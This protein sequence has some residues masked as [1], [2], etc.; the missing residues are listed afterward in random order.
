MLKGNSGAININEKMFVD[1]QQMVNMTGST[2]LPPT[3]QQ[4]RIK[5]AGE[6]YN[7]RNRPCLNHKKLNRSGQTSGLS[8]SIERSVDNNSSSLDHSA[9]HI[10][11]LQR[12]SM[13][14]PSL[15][16][17]NDDADQ[18]LPMIKPDMSKEFDPDNDKV[19]MPDGSL[20]SDS[21][22]NTRSVQSQFVSRKNSLRNVKA[23]NN[24]SIARREAASSLLR[25][26]L[27]DKP[28]EVKLTGASTTKANRRNLKDKI[29]EESQRLK[30]PKKRNNLF[31]ETQ[32]SRDSVKSRFNADMPSSLSSVN[33]RHA[34]TEQDELIS[35]VTP[36]LSRV[37]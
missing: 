11:E 35:P 24:S 26:N 2:K 29:A 28:I 32:R 15:S 21:R 23:E 14:T 6:L 12:N 5:D 18:L 34:V 19:V 1:V 20:V 30:K 8:R 33:K 13:V 37:R 16:A 7:F 25:L 22:N 31:K 4:K 17:F 3:L 9:M 36:Q 27:D 10:M